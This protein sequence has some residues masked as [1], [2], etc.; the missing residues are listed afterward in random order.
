MPIPQMFL[1]AQFRQGA[2]HF[3]DGDR[4]MRDINQLMRI[5]P[6][7]TDHAVLCMHGQAISICI[8]LHR[9]DNRTQRNVLEF[10]DSLDRIAYLSPFD[11]KLM[12]VIDMLI[13]AAAASAEIWTLWR[14]TIGRTLF[15]FDQLCF[16]E[17][18]LFP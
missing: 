16:R 1:F 15:N 2:I 6:K 5:A 13:R 7:K 17:L 11:G 9:R 14:Y 10:P 4:T 18:F 12:L 8:L 3:I